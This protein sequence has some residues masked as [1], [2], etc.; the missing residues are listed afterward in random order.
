MITMGKETTLEYLLLHILPVAISGFVAIFCFWL[1]VFREK[2]KEKKKKM[3]EAVKHK[4]NIV[5]SLWEVG[6][7]AGINK[8]AI[9]KCKI[10]PKGDQLNVT[11]Y[12]LIPFTI[13]FYT[14]AKDSILFD[15]D[16]KLK[17][18]VLLLK[19]IAEDANKLVSLHNDIPSSTDK[20]TAYLRYSRQR[21]EQIIKACDNIL[22][23]YERLIKNEGLVVLFLKNVDLFEEMRSTIDKIEKIQTLELLGPKLKPGDSGT[24]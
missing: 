4:E 10:E 6:L 2:H 7:C 12:L 8:D 14:I 13:D 3:S 24:P 19:I 17:S 21:E 23:I 9:S 11:K 1:G 5:L 22:E 16:Y 18:D 20:E 15:F